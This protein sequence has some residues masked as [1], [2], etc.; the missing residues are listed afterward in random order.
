MEFFDDKKNWGENEVKHGRGWE[1]PELRIK[2]NE[3]LHKLWFVLLKEK[4]MLLTM[5]HEG[6][7]QHRLFASPER[8]DKVQ[9]S[10]ENLETVVRERNRA[11]YELETGETGERPGR[12]VSGQLGI[13]HFYRSC[14]HVIP[15]FFNKKWRMEHVFHYKG[16]AV[17]KFLQKYREK[18]WNAKRKVLNR[19]RNEVVHLMKRFPHLD[20]KTVQAKYPNVNIDRLEKRDMFRGHQVPKI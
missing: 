6:V 16:T 10:M 2:S 7:H 11:Y 1:L 14:E 19:D 13:A 20:K 5:E 15:Y 18:L 12:K 9:E 4:N 8:I 3:D 17:R